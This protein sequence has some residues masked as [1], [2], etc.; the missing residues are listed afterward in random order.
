LRKDG[1]GE[2]D[3]VKKEWEVEKKEE[4]KKRVAAELQTTLWTGVDCF[5]FSDILM[6]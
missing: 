1:R 6:G 3:R 2:E 5:F 4:R